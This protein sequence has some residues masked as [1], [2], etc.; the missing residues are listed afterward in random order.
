MNDPQ[1]HYTLA[2]E[3]LLPYAQFMHQ[4]GTLKN[5]PASWKDLPPQVRA[6]L[7]LQ[8][9]RSVVPKAGQMLVE[10]FP[11]ADKHYMVCYPFEGRLAHQT[12][13]KD[14]RCAF[15]THPNATK[16]GIFHPAPPNTL[17]TT[18]TDLNSRC[19]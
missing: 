4:V 8:R 12:T 11:R 3:R 5:R 19:G 1:V 14:H 16:A 13:A 18:L 17:S 7:S 6:W 15:L 9:F 2:P 10:T